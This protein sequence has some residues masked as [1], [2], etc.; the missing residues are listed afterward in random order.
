MNRFVVYIDG[1]WQGGS[2]ASAKE[3]EA[4]GQKL[5]AGTSKKFEVRERGVEKPAPAPSKPQK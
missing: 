4:V 3:A 1:K 5:T 2:F